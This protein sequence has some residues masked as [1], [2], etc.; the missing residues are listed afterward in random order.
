MVRKFAPYLLIAALAAVVYSNTATHE[1][2]YDDVP[3]ILNNPL[4]AKI[5]NL[6]QAAQLLRE[7]WRPLT[8]FSYAFTMLVA[9]PDARAFHLTNILIHVINS[10]LVFGIARQVARQ[11]IADETP[12]VFAL[13]AALIHAVHPLYTEA[14]AY[15]WGRSSSLCA[16][17]YFSSLLLT[18]AGR[19]EP[20]RRK[21]LWYGFAV[22]SGIVAW[23]TK[24][25]AITLPLV[26]AGYFLLTASWR[27]AAGMLLVPLGIA[28]SRWADIV[29]VYTRVRENQLL[30]SVGASPALEPLSYFLTHVKVS[31]FYYLRMFAFPLNQSVEPQIE[32]VTRLADPTFLG[33]VIILVALLVLGATVARGKP[34]VSFALL[35]LLVSP[36]TAY[37]F[38]PLADVVAEHRVYVSGLGFDL[39]AAW[40]LSRYPRYAW[41][42]IAAVL[43]VLGSLTYQ[44]NRVWANSL[45]LWEDAER[46]SPGLARPHLNLGLAYQ[47]YGRL[48]A[49]LSEYRHALS[50]NPRLAPA[51][52]NMGG[53]YYS[54]NDLDNA[55]S[56]LNTASEL[57]PSLA[58]P[59]LNLA[60]IAMRRNQAAKALELIEKAA[61][62]EDSCLVHLNKGDA[63]SQLGR[64]A[65]AIR[66]YSRAIELAPDLPQL[67]EQAEKRLQYLRSIEK[68][69]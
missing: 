19:R 24:E 3:G 41:A 59:Y 22:L 21:Y 11:W 18:M 47:S 65:E 52:I 31:V 56:A 48:D 68:I 26:I 44:R 54:R 53:I 45:T 61:S 39:L 33:A 9:G 12:S 28:A 5:T 64:Y 60:V 14:I 4:I 17:F 67:K 55:E 35:T 2:V 6:S 50:I 69:P 57:A 58:E 8:Q 27:A 34:V 7:P 23:K 25:E 62:L 10:L 15:V 20:S 66:E 37:A 42:S 30:V 51:Y 49:A 43:L 40:I 29:D 36:L 38:M 13:A 32:P 46:K 1:F 16:L 63:L